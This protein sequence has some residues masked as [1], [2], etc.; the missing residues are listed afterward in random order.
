[1][2]QAEAALAGDTEPESV[3]IGSAAPPTPSDAQDAMIMGRLIV[4]PLC[5]SAVGAAV[6]GKWVGCPLAWP[7]VWEVWSLWNSSR[8]SPQLGEFKLPPCLALDGA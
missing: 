5:S 2:T 1:M 7:H 8:P 3:T 6:L 4:V